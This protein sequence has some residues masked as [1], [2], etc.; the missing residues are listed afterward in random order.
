[1]ALREDIEQAINRANAESGSDTPDFILAEYLMNCLHAFDSAV[2]RR[3]KWYGRGD[4]G[5]ASVVVNVPQARS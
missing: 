1:M 3:E 2:A 5:V 4:K